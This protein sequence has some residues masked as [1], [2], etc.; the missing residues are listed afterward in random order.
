MLSHSYN[1]L[2]P[3]TDS[4]IPWSNVVHFWTPTLHFPFP[5]TV[6]C[7]RHFVTRMSLP[8]KRTIAWV[9]KKVSENEPSL[10]H[11][12]QRHIR[13][14]FILI[15]QFVHLH[16]YM[17]ALSVHTHTAITCTRSTHT[18]TNIMSAW[19]VHCYQKVTVECDYILKLLKHTLSH[20]SPFL[21]Q[22]N[23]MEI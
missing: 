3:H 2:I 6:L 19:H 8:L 16:V 14:K 4:S 7:S 11:W 1:Y 22:Q 13:I 20:T 18:L 5:F 23:V 17:W 21:I 9:V 15:D 12:S 10:K